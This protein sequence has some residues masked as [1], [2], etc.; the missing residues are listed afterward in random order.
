MQ[1][2]KTDDFIDSRQRERGRV[3]I[4]LGRYLNNPSKDED[5]LNQSGKL[6]RYPVRKFGTP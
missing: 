3:E 1:R 6:E 5:D 2:L 4:L